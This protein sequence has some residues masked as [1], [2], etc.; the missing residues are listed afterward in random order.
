MICNKC[1][2]DFP[3]NELDESHDVPTYIFDG[4]RKERKKEADKLGRHWLCKKCHDIYENC[5]FSNM[6][7]CADYDTKQRMIKSAI[8]FA[9]RWFD[10]STT[11]TTK[12]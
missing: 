6:I 11:R 2:K 8:D 4:D 3:E 1:K 10:G 7:K 5:V 12:L 9:K